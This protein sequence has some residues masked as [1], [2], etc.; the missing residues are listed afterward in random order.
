MLILMLMFY[1][2]VD[3][4]MQKNKAENIC[5]VQWKPLNVITDNV[6]IW[7]MLSN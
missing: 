3:I 5:I 1:L 4:K 6:I 7:L 2:E